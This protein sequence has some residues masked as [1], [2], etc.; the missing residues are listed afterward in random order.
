MFSHSYDCRLHPTLV[1]IININTVRF[2]YL[3]PSDPLL[4]QSHIIERHPLRWHYLSIENQQIIAFYFKHLDSDPF[5]IFFIIKILMDF[6]KRSNSFS[7]LNYVVLILILS[8]NNIMAPSFAPPQVRV[9][10]HLLLNL[11]TCLHQ[12]HF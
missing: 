11:T 9:Q 5:F 1:F 4:T 12:L 2:L 3:D 7:C 10:F 6:Y 8:L